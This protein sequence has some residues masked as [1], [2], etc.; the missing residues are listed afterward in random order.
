ML[1]K[2]TSILTTAQSVLVIL[3]VVG[4]VAAMISPTTAATLEEPQFSVT[5]ADPILTPGQPNVVTISLQN[6]AVDPNASVRTAQDVSVAMQAGTTPFEVKTGTVKLGS[7]PD[8][9]VA[10]PSFEVS[11]PRTV[12]AGSYSLP[13]VISYVDD[14]QRKTTTVNADVRIEPRALFR[15]SDS[16]TDVSVGDSGTMELNIE[17]IGEQAAAGAT[18]TFESRTAEVSFGGAT[19]ATRFI[20]DWAAGDTK[21]VSVQVDVSPTADR[22]RFPV[23]ARVNYDDE[24]GIPS[25]SRTLVTGFVPEPEQSFAVENVSSSLRV[26]AKGELHGTIVNTGTNDARNAIVRLVT[27]GPTFSPLETEYAIGDIEPGTRENFDFTIEISES[28][29]S[30]PRQLS[31]LVEYRN[32]QGDRRQSDTLDL[33]TTIGPKQ[34]VFSVEV[35]ES[36]VSAGSSATVTLEVTNIDDEPVS[37]VSAKLFPDEPI[38]TTDDEAFV[39]R[40][41]PGE[42]A[43]LKFGVQV[44]EDAIEKVYPISVD[45]QYDDADGDTLLS[46][47]HTLP[48]RVT[49]PDRSQGPSRR[50]LIAGGLVGAILVIGIIVIIYRRRG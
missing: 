17:N 48:L 43:E 22:D 14:E 50:L 4:L 10:S 12:D 39:D 40:L 9:A 30:G 6:D 42:S 19:S 37:D 2:P 28:A 41:D 26:G 13:I 21:T 33:Q 25:Q 35:S 15:I 20:G 18:V 34:D 44:G 49:T 46:D 7:L 23:Y 38:S 1:D 24:A 45:F 36:R 11:V 16:Q 5:V 47:T 8:G 27:T 31:L 32:E 29:T 3:L